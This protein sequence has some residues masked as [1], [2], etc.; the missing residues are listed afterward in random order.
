MKK[1]FIICLMT[2]AMLLLVA[3]GK[4]TVTVTVD[5]GNKVTEEEN[6]VTKVERTGEMTG[7]LNLEDCFALTGRGYVITGE[8]ESGVVC[9]GDEVIVVKE[10]GN[11]IKATVIEIQ[12][13]RDTLE[14]AEVGQSVGILVDLENKI[15]ITNQDKMEVYGKQETA[16]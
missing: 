15:E 6:A 2:C 8:V 10:D 13:L 4:D 16:Q 1:K 7:T 5:E 14:M 3:C 12:I 9:V 11:E